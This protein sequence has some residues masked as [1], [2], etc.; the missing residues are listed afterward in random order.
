MVKKRLA[1]KGAGTYYEKKQNNK[2]LNALFTQL[3]FQIE[4]VSI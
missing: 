2:S 3:I 4:W 1:S